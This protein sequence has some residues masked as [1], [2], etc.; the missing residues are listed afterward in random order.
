MYE[1][2]RGRDLIYF[3][4]DVGIEVELGVGGSSSQEEGGIVR[5][6]EV[7]DTQTEGEVDDCDCY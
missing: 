3:E 1:R 4:V 5:W 2:E 6:E 7:A